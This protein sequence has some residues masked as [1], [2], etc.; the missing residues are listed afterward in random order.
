MLDPQIAEMDRKRLSGAYADPFEAMTT[1]EARRRAWIIRDDIYPAPHI[2]VKSCEDLTI[3][4]PAGDMA[5]RIVRPLG[6][7]ASGTVLYFH[8]GA[9]MVGDLDSHQAHVAR[10]ANLAGAVVVSVDYRLAPDHLFPAACDDAFAAFDWVIAHVGD[11]GG[12]A[13]KIAVAGDSAGGALA[14]ATAILARDRGV[15]LAAQFLIYPATDMRQ[16][17]PEPSTVALKYLGPDYETVSLDWRASPALADLTGV[18]PAIIGTGAHDFLHQQSVSF[19]ELL[20]GANVPVTL[21]VFPDLNHSFF[22]YAGV[23]EPCAEASN[24]MCE[25]LRA[26]LHG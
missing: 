13:S 1:E 23:S 21:R 18:A 22:S 25:D 3:A 24:L 17:G 9:W 4:G 20:G 8:G 19:S 2:D 10:I 12:D 26:T 15:P 5:I 7:E 16:N 11:L 14:A 6:D